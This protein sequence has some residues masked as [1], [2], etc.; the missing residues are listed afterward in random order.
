MMG[1]MNGKYLLRSIAVACAAALALTAS[2]HRPEVQARFTADPCQRISE[3]R[4]GIDPGGGNRLLFALATGYR[5]TQVVITS[6]VLG[7]LGYSAEWQDEGFTGKNG[8]A[9]PGP[10]PVNSLQTPS[11]SFS[12]SEA[13]GRTDPGTMLPY[14]PV[15]TDS[16][17]GG[18]AGA[19]FNNYFRG[20]G[21]WPDESLWTYMESG[22]YEQAAV[23]N[24]NRPPDME[25]IHGRTFAIFLHAGSA[26][27][28]GCISTD[29]GTVTRV[30][31]GAKPG[32]H[33]IMGVESEIFAQS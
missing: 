5:E 32:E 3:L 26:E 24:Y 11:G 2:G 10:V 29:L 15:R 8:F 7:Q 13:F 23:I 31:K 17:W 20:A 9:T 28:W 6:C 18:S 21:T 25:A 12:M 4:P 30:L 14:N 1:C 16:Y 33:I 22:I 19:N 27:T